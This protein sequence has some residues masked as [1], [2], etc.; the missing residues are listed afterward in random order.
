MN[1]EDDNGGGAEQSAGDGSSEGMLSRDQAVRD[2][3]KGAGVVVSGLFLN[4]AIAFLAQVLAARYLSVGGFG[5]LT[6]GTT[7]LNLGALV[8]VL[9]FPSGLTRYLPRIQEHRQRPLAKVIFALCIPFATGVALLLVTYAE[10]FATRVLGSPDV[11]TSIRVFGAAIPFAAALN[12]SIGGIRGL[13]YSRYR[14]YVKNLL[15]PIIRFSMV[16]GAIY[17][18]LG[19]FGVSAAYAIPFVTSAT[20]ATYYFHRRLPEAGDSTNIQDLIP[21]VVRYSLPFTITGLTGFVYKSIDIFLLLYFL[22]SASVGVYAVAYALAK[23]IDTFSTA[24]NYLGSPVASQLESQER[25]GE[26]LNVQ[27]S[28]AR[29]LTIASVSA[30]VP[31]ASISRDVIHVIYGGGY[32]E[33]A[34]V[35]S[36]LVVGFAVYNVLSLHEPILEALG[37]SKVMASNNTIVA[38]MNVGLNILL[39][40]EYG[41]TGAAIATSASYVIL[42]MLPAIEVRYLV[43]NTIVSKRI[44]ATALIAVP[45]VFPAMALAPEVPKSIFW[46][47]LYGAGFAFVYIGIVVVTFGFTN[48]DVMI[49]RS[50]EDKY[51]I[52]LGPVDVIL[53][54]FS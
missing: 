36:I 30:L 7:L 41:I 37:H 44:L 51:G 46:I 43:G 20:V 5:G 47:G 25:L 40:P 15:H 6:V 8:T 14:V 38:V 17:L 23:L 32:G 48:T 2:V 4:M 49:V 26:A 53:D 39:I 42:G 50:F 52:D 13:K 27:R 1:E 33:G 29:W 9:G 11:V 54:R 22:D 18:G 28:V 10:F 3:L 16:I 34:I 31:M 45:L 21:S 24:F 12:I 19:Q 35:L